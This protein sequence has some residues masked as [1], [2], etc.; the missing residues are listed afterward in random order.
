MII[1]LPFNIGD[2][3]FYKQHQYSGKFILK[4]LVISQIEITQIY[5]RIIGYEERQNTQ[6]LY[7]NDLGKWWFLKREDWG[8]EE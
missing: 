5:T 2:T 4:P 1:N 7:L 3:V 6:V 8:D